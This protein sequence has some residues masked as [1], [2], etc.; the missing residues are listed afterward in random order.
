M[1]S[2]ASI[3][4]AILIA[5]ATPADATDHS[6]LWWNPNESGWGVNVTE[7]AGTLFLTFFLYSPSGQPTWYVAPS[8]TF[9]A[10]NANGGNVFSGALYQTAGP[11]FGA[12]FNPSL[13]TVSQ[14]G[15]VTF[16]ANSVTDA[17]LAYSVSGVTV[18]KAL[19][20]QTFKA[21][22]NVYGDY[23]GGL[24]IDTTGCAVSAGNGHFE[25]SVEFSISGTVLSSSF[26]VV[27]GDG[28]CTVTAAY[29][30]DG[31]MGSII[32][33]ITCSNGL[34]GNAGLFEIEANLNGATGR[35]EAFYANGCHDVGH[36]AGV[37]R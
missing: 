19:F 36:W 20:R 8:V 24:V 37:R 34:N 31:R 10:T 25:G 33:P 15:S 13:V 23:I 26:T 9:Q 22:S 27:I 4:A 30:Q 6:D 11:W 1:K 7:Q 14:V 2:N 21:N 32:A 35:Y 29:R 18:T 12:A 3:L 5:I 16:T 28:I 17:T